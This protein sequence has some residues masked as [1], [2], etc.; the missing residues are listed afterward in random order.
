MGYYTSFTLNVDANGESVPGVLQALEELEVF[1]TLSDNSKAVTGYTYTKWYSSTDDLLQIS[2]R[3]PAA[4]FTLEGDGEE[5][6]DFWIAYIQNGAMQQC[7]GR[8][9]YD[10][11]NPKKMTQRVQPLGP[12]FKAPVA[13]LI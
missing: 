11:Y 8:I 10:D 3:F 1:D 9:T 2:I 6:D 5:S 7:L 4:M 13:D 12:N